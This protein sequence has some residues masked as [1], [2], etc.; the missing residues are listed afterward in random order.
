MK[1]PIALQWEHIKSI[2]TIKKVQITYH[3][4]FTIRSAN[5]GQ[6]VPQTNRVYSKH[7]RRCHVLYPKPFTTDNL[8]L[9]KNCFLK[10]QFGDFT[11]NLKKK[12]WIA[13]IWAHFLSPILAF[14]YIYIYISPCI[15]F[16]L[17]FHCSQL[18]RPPSH[19]WS[20]TCAPPASSPATKTLGPKLSSLLEPLI[21]DCASGH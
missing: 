11:P 7:L 1:R 16:S 4:H 19:Q 13:R 9:Y 6:M 17:F 3:S 15:T 20:L 12:N 18:R 14:I 21:V 8:Q 5:N 2:K 10:G